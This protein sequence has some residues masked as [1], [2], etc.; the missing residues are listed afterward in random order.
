MISLLYSSQYQKKMKKKRKIRSSALSIM[1]SN[2]GKLE[3]LHSFLNDYK[4]AVMFYVNYLFDN[5]YHYQTKDG[6]NITFSIKKDLLDC[7]RFIS[8]VD[9]PYKSNL[10]SRALSCASNQ[11]ISIV[12]SSIKRRKNLLFVRGELK[13]S[14]KRTRSINNRINKTPIIKPIIDNVYPELNSICCNYEECELK[15]FDN[16]IVLSSLG[17]KYGKIILP[18]NHTKHSRKLEKKGKLLNSF[19]ITKNKIHLRYEM[20]KPTNKTEGFIVGAD[21][22]IKTCLTF[23]DGQFTKPCKHGH[24]LDSINKKIARKIPG[25]KGFYKAK[26]HQTNYTNYSINQLNLSNIKQINL[27]KI[28]NFR[29]G[30]NVGRYLN[31]FNESLIRSKLLD[32]AQELGVQVLEQDSYFRSQRCSKCGYVDSGNRKSKLFRCKHCSYQTDAD[33]NASCNH[34]KILPSARPLF[35]LSNRPKKFFWL[36][37]GF[38][39]MKDQEIAVPDSQK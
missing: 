20:P 18:V 30:K 3:M 1:E 34:E 35:K 5:E 4:N 12:K 22:G 8:I 11:A 27:E 26:G 13:N 29:H 6:Y 33:H 15:H 36:V 7:P 14:K 24:T 25:S 9:I 2:P 31:C 17:K 38:F 32:I 28:S 16:V 23:S 19:L 21:Q 10:S 37:E 39:D